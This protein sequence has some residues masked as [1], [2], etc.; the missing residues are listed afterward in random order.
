[1]SQGSPEDEGK[2]TCDKQ[3]EAVKVDDTVRGKSDAAKLNS[4]LRKMEQT[5]VKKQ[6]AQA[7]SGFTDKGASK[8]AAVVVPA[9]PNE[10]SKA[11]KK[12]VDKLDLKAKMLALK[13]AGKESRANVPA[14]EEKS[15]VQKSAVG[16]KK[17]AV[18]SNKQP[19]EKR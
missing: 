3:V 14:A 6:M 15:K 19:K 18:S 11:E 16:S 10:I 4:T 17:S 5:K 7:A 1:M 12:P 13:K 8:K 2:R 9:K